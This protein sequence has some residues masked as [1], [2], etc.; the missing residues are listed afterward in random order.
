MEM[1]SQIAKQ[2]DIIYRPHPVLPSVDCKRFVQPWKEKQTVRQIL[3]DNGIDQYQP[4]SITVNDRLL[5]VKEWDSVVPENGQIINVH[6]EV[7]GGGGGGGGGADKAVQI[8]AVVAIVALIVV[9]QQYE[10]G[11]MAAEFAGF[12]SATAW[13]TGI[14]IAGSMIIQ[15][16]AAAVATGGSAASLGGMDG[17]SGDYSSPSPT[18]SLSGGS[19]RLRP[20]ESMPVIMGQHRF[21]P[22]AGMKSY[23]E[24]QSNDQ[25]LYQI[26]HNGVS[27]A[28]FSN[29]KIGTTPI[30]NYS[31]YEW[32]YH[33]ENGKFKNFPGN[34]DSIAGAALTKAGGAIIRTTSSNTTTIGFDIESVLYYGNDSGGLDARSVELLIEYRP[35]G[36]STW[37]QPSTLSSSNPD[38]V[39][40]S[41]VNEPYTVDEGYWSGGVDNDGWSES[42][43]VP[44]VVTRYRSVYRTGS[45]G[46]IHITGSSQKPIRSSFKFSVTQGSYEVKISRTTDDSTSSREQTS[47]NWSVLKSYQLDNGDYT[48]QNRIGLT[49]KATE[50]LNGS[51]QQLSVDASSKA[52]Y[53]NGTSWVTGETSNPAHWFMDFVLGRKDTNG[54]LLYGIG[55]NYAQL[56]WGNLVAWAD[57]CET[58]G[59]TF[60][61]VIDG[62][63]TAFDVLSAIA[64]CGFASPSWSSGKLGVI[65]DARSASPVASFGMSNI[66]KD[67]FNVSYI[68]EQLAEEIV[69]RYVDPTNDWNQSE[70]R[71]T[72]PGVTTPNRTSTVDLWGCTDTAMAGKFANYLAAQQ[73]YRK[74]RITWESDFQGFVCNRGDVVLLSHD[75]T[76]WGYSG[77]IV[78]VDGDTVT[79]DRS[80]PRNGEIEYLMITAP[81]GTMTIHNVDAATSDQDV[82]TLDTP[83]TL[84]AD[85]LPMDHMWFFSPLS[86]PGKKVKILSVQPSSSSRVKIIATDEYDEFYDAW[87][88]SFVTPTIDTLLPSVPVTATH[89]TL[90]KR[91]S[92]TNGYRINKVAASWQSSGSTTF[93][94]VK[95]F[96]NDN[97]LQEIAQNYTGSIEFDV[98][99]TGTVRVEVTPFGMDN[100]GP[101]VQET[102][103]IPIYE[104]PDA[105]TNVT[106]N[107]GDTGNAATFSWDGVYGAQSYVVDIVVGGTVKRTVDVGNTLSYVYTVNDAHADGGPFRTYTARIYSVSNGIQSTGYG[108]ATFSNPQIGLLQNIRLTSLPNSLWIEFDKPT[109]ADFKGSKVWMSTNSLFTPS[110]A[111]LVYD[112]PD[113]WITITTD[114]SGHLLVPGTTYYLYVAGYDTFGTDSLTFSTKLNS[115]ILSPVGGMNA[116]DITS[117]YIADAA[118]TSA[119]IQDLAVGSAKIADA[120]ISNAKIASAAITSAK[121][122]DLNVARVH[123]QSGAAT[124]VFYGS[125]SNIAVTA[126]TYTDI[127][128]LPITADSYT[129][130][131]IVTC[132]I[133]LDPAGAYVTQPSNTSQRLDTSIG[134]TGLYS[135]ASMSYYTN[136]FSGWAHPPGP[137]HVHFTGRLWRMPGQSWPSS[138]KVNVFG[139]LKSADDLTMYSNGFHIWSCTLITTVLNR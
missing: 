45:G 26:F 116:G 76:Q 30:T 29:W 67:T 129:D 28:T 92:I 13:S 79:L 127:L 62:S 78:S 59:L 83:I 10:L 2:L 14:V 44:N 128:T 40:G 47:T 94:R 95:I 19:N 86:T 118:I 42:T 101:T 58:E 69:V 105:P 12:G 93:S 16:I 25:Y 88:G 22:D 20:Y 106:L 11:A 8:V 107:V 72:V 87:D 100:Y 54:K 131:I 112:G 115:A 89:L 52:I 130:S 63:Q 109:D 137:S 18:Y 136:K 37:L 114:A 50:Q 60:N 33:D 48:G 132:Y 121:I 108:Y 65:F 91:V 39:T 56:D 124:S 74:R 24:Y 17:L 46:Y 1:K 75:L 70:V 31:N 126:S 55:F 34:V 73:Y 35:V 23:T 96:L 138:I 110:N 125:S 113:T 77:R 53:Y 84:Q 61:A 104:S 117:T 57:F 98:A 43:W 64:R 4:I 90:S 9:T 111:T 81:D 80:V 82:L 123:L 7:M 134:G 135:N 66:I 97:L 122:A 68:T 71:T 6:A 38:A 49:I 103:V 15:G 133:L 120:A 102:L 5:T 36:T 27:D 139:Y 119:K 85:Y 21:F 3:I 99:T 51:I 32:H 41:Y